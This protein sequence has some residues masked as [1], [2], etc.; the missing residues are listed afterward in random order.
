MFLII[1]QVQGAQQPTVLKFKALKAAED[2]FKTLNK[3]I[4]PH[5]DSMA[6]SNEYLVMVDDYGHRK[7]IWSHHIQSVDLIDV[8]QDLESQAENALW[9][10]RAQQKANMLVQN[11]PRLK[12]QQSAPPFLAS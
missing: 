5:A 7:G 6:F 1:L 2:L 11:D 4:G 9:N 3:A 8:Q 10:A 12:L